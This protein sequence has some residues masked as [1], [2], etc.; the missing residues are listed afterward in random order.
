M[1]PMSSPTVSL[2][3]A[4]IAPRGQMTQ[5][6]GNVVHEQNNEFKRESKLM[7]KIGYDTRFYKTRSV[8]M[9]RLS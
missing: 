7:A 8:H 5:P 1:L 4:V 2:G 6:N 9:V 3:D